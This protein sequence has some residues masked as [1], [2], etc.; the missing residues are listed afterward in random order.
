M[1]AYFTNT[2]SNC[3]LR[4]NIYLQDH[5]YFSLHRCIAV[6]QYKIFFIHLQD[7]KLRVQR[8]IGKHLHAVPC[9]SLTTQNSV[10]VLKSPDE[11][12]SLG[13]KREVSAKTY[14]HRPA[15]RMKMVRKEDR[16]LD[17]NL[18]EKVDVLASSSSKG[19]DGEKIRAVYKRGRHLEKR[20]PNNLNIDG[21]CSSTG[22]NS[23]HYTVG[24][25]NLA[26]DTSSYEEHMRA[27]LHRIEIEAY[28]NTLRV[29]FAS[30]SFSW[31]QEMLMTD[32][33]FRLHI[34]DDE[35]SSELKYL[36]YFS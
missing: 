10:N 29:L 33:R 31:P 6:Y 17:G 35:H 16:Q 13:V 8:R 18:P 22:S 12:S 23:L 24:E 26:V 15:K 36:K 30:G 9:Q 25:D 2:T 32:L 7:C 27:E 3:G 11:I 34:S 20:T 21:A 4:D 28:R 14:D 19:L 1:G 5:I